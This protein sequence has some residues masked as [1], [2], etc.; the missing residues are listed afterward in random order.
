[1]SAAAFLAIDR[2]NDRCRRT[3]KEHGDANKSDNRRHDE[4]HATVNP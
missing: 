2:R 4:L 3:D 1:M